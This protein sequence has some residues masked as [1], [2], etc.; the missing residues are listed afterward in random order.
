L[1]LF[2]SLNTP[3]KI[4]DFLDGIPMNFED[5]GIDTC[6]SPRGVLKANKCHCIE[7]A[8]LAAL[9][10]RVHGHPPLLLDL[11]ASADNFDH[12][13]ALY[14]KA[15]AWGAISKTN[16]HSLRFREPVYAS[17]R[18]LVMS[19]FHEYINSAGKKTLRSYSDPVDLS[20]FDRTNWMTT[21]GEV[22]AIPNHLAVTPHHP[23]LTEDQIANLRDADQIEKKAAEIVEYFSE[24]MK[25]NL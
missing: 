21:A 7:G 22:W 24:Q 10:L 2:G 15:G 18:E 5:G 1:A 20:M 17:V 3:G 16:H 12:V 9:M 25:P 6:L 11:T 23:I 8:I 4:Q 13:I 14:Q 19:Y